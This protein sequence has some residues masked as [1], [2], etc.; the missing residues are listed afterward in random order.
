MCGCALCVIDGGM[1]HAL[2][3]SGALSDT[4]QRLLP[5]LPPS[6]T[7]LNLYDTKFPLHHLQL[8]AALRALRYLSIDV[9]KG[10]QCASRCAPSP[11]FRRVSCNRI[12]CCAVARGVAFLTLSTLQGNKWRPR[13]HRW[14]PTSRC[15]S[16]AA[17]RALRRRLCAQCFHTTRAPTQRPSITISS[18]CR[19]AARRSDEPV[20]VQEAADDT[21]VLGFSTEPWQGY[22]TNHQCTRVTRVRLVRRCLCGR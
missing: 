18:R 15:W 17:R 13:W 10:C 14:Q 1:S 3:R 21:P 5:A 16:S 22:N 8:L 9:V 12:A 6:L 7:A 20:R 19:R 2:P 11:L 4:P